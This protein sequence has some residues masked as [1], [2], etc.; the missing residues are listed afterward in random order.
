MAS[1]YLLKLVYRC[2]YMLMLPV[3]SVQLKILS[4]IISIVSRLLTSGLPCDVICFQ[5]QLFFLCDKTLKIY[6][7][8]SFCNIL[9][10]EYEHIFKMNFRLSVCFSKKHCSPASLK[11]WFW[12]ME[13]KNKMTVPFPAICLLTYTHTYTQ[14]THTHMHMNTH[15][16]RLTINKYE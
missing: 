7:C 1:I 14:H 5:I 3:I 2:S 10:N 11:M 15:K 12:Y 6:T 13:L 9:I 8:W 16:H 4:G